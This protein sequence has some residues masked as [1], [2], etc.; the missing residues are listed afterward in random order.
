MSDRLIKP[1]SL[2]LG[3]IMFLFGFLKFFHP[4]NGWFDVQIQQSHLPHASILTAKFGE[5]ITGILFVLPTLLPSLNRL[6]KQALTLL[7]SAMIVVQMLVA[8]Y[9]HLQPTVPASVLPLGIKPPF[10]PATV[11]LLGILTAVAVLKQ[12]QADRAIASPA[13]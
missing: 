9:V 8:I 4:F 12:W 13:R 7:G 2:T 1:L 3:A 11:L 10:I 6:T 5:M